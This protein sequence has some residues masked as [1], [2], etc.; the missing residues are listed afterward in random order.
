VE[1]KKLVI[2][3][4]VCNIEQ[5]LLPVFDNINKLSE[6]FELQRCI[7]IESNST[8]NSI[9]LLKEKKSYL[10]CPLDVYII[11]N[12]SNSPYDRVERIAKARN[13]YLDMVEK[14]YG[15]CDY[16][17]VLDFNETNVEPYNI[18][19]IKSNF[20]INNEWDMICANQDKNYYDLYAL[21]H[22]VWMPFNCWQIINDRPSFMSMNEAKNIYIRSRFI[23]IPNDHGPIE[24]E[25]AFGG[26]AFIKIQSIKGARHSHLDE[27]NKPDCEWVSFC[28][29]LDK[30]LINPKFI[31]MKKLSRHVL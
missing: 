24:V 15:D 12:K 28:K 8:D 19:N 1:K 5:T 27:N 13:M 6:L 29:S 22:K 2:A 7:L 18:E 11:N 25:S 14:N 31:N 3:A 10:K 30:V 23:N 17:L 4:A 16:L 26:T 9:N 21:R 20:I